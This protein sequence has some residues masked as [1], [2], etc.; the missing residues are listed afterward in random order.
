[1]ILRLQLRRFLCMKAGC[2]KRTFAERLPGVVRPSARCSERLADIQRHV[3]L[4][5]S[6]TPELA[7]SVVARCWMR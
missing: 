7:M 2:L 6:G 1:M 4:A 5:P 3:T